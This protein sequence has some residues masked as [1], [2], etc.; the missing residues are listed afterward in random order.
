MKGGE[1]DVTQKVRVDTLPEVEYAVDTGLSTHTLDRSDETSRHAAMK[2]CENAYRAWA[3][4]FK[5]SNGSTQTTASVR[6]RPPLMAGTIHETLR[7]E[8]ISRC[9]QWFVK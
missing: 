4:V 5:N 7:M 8:K 2:R 3:C 6:A 1:G 9:Y